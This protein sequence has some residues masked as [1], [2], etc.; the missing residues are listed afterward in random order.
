[1]G[2]VYASGVARLYSIAFLSLPKWHKDVEILRRG[3]V[4]GEDLRVNSR[5]HVLHFEGIFSCGELS[6]AMET[7][8]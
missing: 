5:F 1:M 4:G 3:W 7:E 6:Q 8:H 2:D